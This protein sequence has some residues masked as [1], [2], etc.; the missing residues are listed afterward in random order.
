MYKFLD[1]NFDLS[2]DSFYFYRKSKE[3]MIKISRL[4]PDF[5]K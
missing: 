2:L 4:W 3:R 1:L 5:Q